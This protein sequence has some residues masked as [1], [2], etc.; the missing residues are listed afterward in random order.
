MAM[1]KEIVAYCGLLCNECPAYIATQADDLEMRIKTAKGWS[2]KEHKVD[3]DDI[4]CDGCP[5]GGRLNVF[6][7]ECEVRRCAVEK[8]VENCARC[9][10]YA[11]D[12]LTGLW[13]I[14]QTPDAVERLEKLRN[15]HPGA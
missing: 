15:P 8:G 10:D 5:A 11:C 1:T 12:R 6:C 4:I 2:T 3:A 13:N 14:I 7:S 9:G